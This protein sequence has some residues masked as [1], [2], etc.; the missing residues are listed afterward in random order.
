[1]TVLEL[2]DNP[3]EFYLWQQEVGGE[4]VVRQLDSACMEL[5]EREGTR[6][7]FTVMEKLDGI[8]QRFQDA[9]AV[10]EEFTC[11]D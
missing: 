1:M 10:L 8:A 9:S 7:I 6:A 11:E 5:M 2:L 3:W 4:E